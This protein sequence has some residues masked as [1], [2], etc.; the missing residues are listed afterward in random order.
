VRW[1]LT[2]GS[3]DRMLEARVTAVTEPGVAE[4]PPRR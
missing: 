2:P 4:P 3:Y 1:D